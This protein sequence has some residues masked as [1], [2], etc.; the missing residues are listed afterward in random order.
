MLL[1]VVL[2]NSGI[3]VM[4]GNLWVHP[5]AVINVPPGSGNINTTIQTPK[6]EVVPVTVS[7]SSHFLEVEYGWLNRGVHPIHCVRPDC[8]CDTYRLSYF[9][10]QKYL[11]RFF[12]ACH[13]I[14]SDNFTQRIGH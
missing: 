12:C 8:V 3:M 2:L 9:S 13:P 11:N 14:P 10:I 6:E 4:M 5:S 7:R 1:L